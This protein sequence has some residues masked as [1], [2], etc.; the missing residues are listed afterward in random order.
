MNKIDKITNSEA[1]YFINQFLK[2]REII[3]EFFKR[4]PEDKL[5]YRMVDTPERKSDSP[6]GSIIHI[7][8]TT[9]DYINGV[10]NGELKFGIE[11]DDLKDISGLSKQQLLDMLNK[12]TDE[13]IDVLTDIANKKVKVPWEDKPIGIVGA[14]WGLDSHEILHQGWN[15]ALMDYLNIER[16]PQL[17]EMWG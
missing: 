8:N 10:K 14:L 4:V 12:S 3:V 13:L 16:F 15:L 11:Y 17:K 2:D 9:R 6:R 5:D 1:K 7:I